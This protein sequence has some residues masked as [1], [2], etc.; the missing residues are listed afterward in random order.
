M[1]RMAMALVVI[2][3]A[4]YKESAGGGKNR[5]KRKIW[6]RPWL[7]Q[8]VEG[9]QY[10]NLIQELALEDQD[11]YKNW[12]RLDR[13]QFLE[14]LELIKPAIAKQDIKMR[15]AVLPQDRLAITLHHL[16]TG[17]ARD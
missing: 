2:A 3:M 10:N 7:A 4:E 12:M 11:R 13:N 9:S 1:T 17:A 14:V 8:R 6:T 15:A 16:A 5:K